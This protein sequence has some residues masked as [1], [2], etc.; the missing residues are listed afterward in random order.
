MDDGYYFFKMNASISLII[1]NS[2]KISPSFTNKFIS[3][4]W[5]IVVYIN[6]KKEVLSDFI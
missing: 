4:L 1:P 6:I 2:I 3:P 5:Y